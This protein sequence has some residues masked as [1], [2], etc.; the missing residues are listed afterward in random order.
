MTRAGANRIEGW[1]WIALVCFA[2]L[3]SAACD[4]SGSTPDAAPPDAARRDAARRDAGHPLPR[5][6]EILDPG[7]YDCAATGP[8][9]PPSRPHP[10]GCLLDPTCRGRLIAA[11]RIGVPFAP[12]NSLSALRA[13][14]LLG[15]DM[16]ETDVRLTSDGEVVLVH[17]SDVD[18]TLMGSGAVGA[19]TL[20]AIQA[21][22]MRIEPD[23]PPGDFAC[24]RV[25]TL[26]EVFALARGRIVVELEVKDEAAGVASAI[27]LRDQ[28]L[29]A[30][31]FL[32][33]DPTECAAARAAVPDVPIMTRP[34]A[35]EEVP[36]ALAYDPP[37]ILVHIDVSDPFLRPEILD[38]I[39]GIDA[40]VYGNAFTNGDALALVT[41]D[42]SGY[43]AAFDRG[44][45]VLQCEYPHW[46]LMA[47]GRL[48]AP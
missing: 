36:A 2:G 30:D 17:D 25:P 38:S 22:P 28:D 15:V 27:Y 34:R 9:E 1:E 11:H 14:I 47:L 5:A 7:L 31:G 42:P 8:F 16:V 21:L 10:P 4:G 24:D 19:M 40:E 18:R 44:I 23:L 32:L 3:L 12:E 29:Y 39:H 48:D 37:P 6:A 45:D 35:P 43:V 41:N 13:A 20:G 26:D 46:A 33:C